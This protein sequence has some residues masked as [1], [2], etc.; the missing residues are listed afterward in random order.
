LVLSDEVIGGI[1][2]I[3]AEIPSPAALRI[4]LSPTLLLREA[5]KRFN[6]SRT[7]VMLRT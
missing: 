3:H 4:L 2:A 6:I 5:S 7:G 1:E